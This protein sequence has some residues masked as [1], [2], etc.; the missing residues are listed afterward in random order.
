MP[1][2]LQNGILSIYL[3]IYT[4][5]IYIPHIY[6]PYVYMVY[7]V[8][9]NVCVVSYWCICMIFDSIF[10]GHDLPMTGFYKDGVFIWW[11]NGERKQGA[12]ENKQEIDLYSWNSWDKI[13]CVHDSCIHNGEPLLTLQSAILGNSF[14]FQ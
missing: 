11:L 10:L 7:I 8:Y 5:T 14:I 12:Q 3:Y 4:Y 9:E 6:I 2:K 13:E 1:M